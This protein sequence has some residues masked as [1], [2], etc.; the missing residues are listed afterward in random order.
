MSYPEGAWF[1]WKSNLLAY[2]EKLME[3]LKFL[4]PLA[5]I[6]VG[7]VLIKRAARKAVQ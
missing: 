2:F 7:V 1:E 4:L 6:V 3:F 5:F